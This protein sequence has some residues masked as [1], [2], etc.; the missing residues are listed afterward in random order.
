MSKEV[1]EG[2]WVIIWSSTEIQ[3]KNP[4]RPAELLLYTITLLTGMSDNRTDEQNYWEY[5]NIKVQI[6]HLAVVS[7]TRCSSSYSVCIIGQ[8]DLHSTTFLSIPVLLTATVSPQSKLSILRL[9]IVYRHQHHYRQKCARMDSNESGISFQTDAHCL[10]LDNC[11]F[12][13]TMILSSQTIP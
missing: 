2:H 13:F 10:R 9:S 11:F 6:F 1:V 12:N 7:D 4:V 8:E 3:N 5:P